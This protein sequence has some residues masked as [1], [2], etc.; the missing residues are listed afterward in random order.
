MSRNA[1]LAS[2]AIQAIRNREELPLVLGRNSDLRES[3][4]IRPDSSLDARR[5]AI[6]EHFSR[7]Q[8]L[9]EEHRKLSAE[10]DSL[11]RA[12]GAQARGRR[13]GL[14][15]RIAEI[16]SEPTFQRAFE[17]EERRYPIP[18]WPFL[19]SAAASYR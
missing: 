8:T 5:L 7:G 16:A 19:L 18:A 2:M 3:A 15:F 4:L 11:Y 9:L 14:R 6:I 17:A 10:Y 13:R 1:I 12:N